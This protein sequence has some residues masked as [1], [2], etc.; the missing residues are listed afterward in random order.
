MADHPLN[1]GA[2]IVSATVSGTERLARRGIVVPQRYEADILTY[3]RVRTVVRLDFHTVTAETPVREVL[4]EVR[5][6][7]AV[8]SDL[9]GGPG[10]L[11]PQV[12]V[13]V[14]PDGTT[15]GYLID[16]VLLQVQGR[17]ENLDLPVSTIAETAPSIVYPDQVMQY[18]LVLM[19]RSGR[20]WVPVIERDHPERTIGY[21]TLQDTLLARSMNLEDEV[22]RESIVQPSV[23]QQGAEV[24][25]K[26]D[27][28]RTEA[29]AADPPDDARPASLSLGPSPTIGR[30]TE[31]EGSWS[32]AEHLS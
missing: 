19:L 10:D 30:G 17:P 18:A 28:S 3:L 22:L 5:T 12:W 13:V 14:R 21:V 6:V 26:I 2:V 27:E 16:L 25:N 7:S 29:T 15:V 32:A 20:S 8:R 11:H 24:V 1:C 4:A 9:V 23:F 31:G